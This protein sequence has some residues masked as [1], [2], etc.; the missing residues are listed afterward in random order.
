M[1]TATTAGGRRSRER[2]RSIER[3]PI[4]DNFTSKATISPAKSEGKTVN[5]RANERML[6]FLSQ[7]KDEFGISASESIRKGI[8]L[9]FIAKNEEKKGRRLAFI[10]ESDSVV[11]EVQSL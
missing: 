4:A 6:F 8:G 10:D 7:L 1:S 5:V 11:V 2:R 3:T 9:F